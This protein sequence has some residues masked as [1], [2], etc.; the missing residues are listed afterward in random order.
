V[1]ALDGSVVPMGEF[2]IGD[3]DGDNKGNQSNGGEESKPRD[4]PHLPIS[5]GNAM[6]V[7]K[8][9]DMQQDAKDKPAENIDSMQFRRFSFPLKSPMI[10]LGTNVDAPCNGSAPSKRW[11]AMV[12]EEAED[13]ARSA[14]LG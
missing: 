11:F 5:D 12:E 7:S 8:T 1:A 6:D 10:S 13:K 4:D 14:L 2:D 9:D 3:G